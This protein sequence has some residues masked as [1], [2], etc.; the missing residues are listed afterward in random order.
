MRGLLGAG[1]VGL[2]AIVCCAGLPLLAAAGLSAATYALAGGIAAGTVAL[3]V[4]VAVLVRVRRRRACAAP[5][6]SDTLRRS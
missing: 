6:I 4:V 3:A 1:G 2:L 5:R